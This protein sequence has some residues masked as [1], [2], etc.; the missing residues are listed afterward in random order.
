MYLYFPARVNVILYPSISGGPNEFANTP[1]LWKPAPFQLVDATTLN[2]GGALL[3]PPPP[4]PPEDG[5]SPGLFT[6]ATALALM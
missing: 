4:P 2:L 1:E 3:G 6:G 5:G